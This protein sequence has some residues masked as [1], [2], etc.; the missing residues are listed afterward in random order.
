MNK[1][2][3]TCNYL[4]NLIKEQTKGYSLSEL[5]YT[6]LLRDEFEKILREGGVTIYEEA[7]LSK[8]CDHVFGPVNQVTL[9]YALSKAERF[10]AKYLS[11]PELK[12]WI[13]KNANRM[14]GKGCHKQVVS[15]INSDEDFEQLVDNEAIRLSIYTNDDNTVTADR[16]LND[17]HLWQLKLV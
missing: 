1:P 17:V 13:K 10:I 15:V 9:Q 5:K 4:T 8:W 2:E 6:A 14:E 16:M 11:T 12:E 3:I 7:A